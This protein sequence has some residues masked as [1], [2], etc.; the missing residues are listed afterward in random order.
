LPRKD[1]V[2]NQLKKKY[3]NHNSIL[4]LEDGE[5]FSGFGIGFEG[6]S[7]GEI[8]F[9]T[10]ITGYQEILTDPSYAGQIINFTFPHIGN[11]GA[12]YED[13]EAEKAWVK[14]AI[15]NTKVTTASNFRAIENLDAWLKK[16]KITAIC[17]VDTRKITLKIRKEGPQRASIFYHK[18]KKLDVKEILKLTRKLPKLE[19]IDLT[20]E[21]TCKKPYEWTGVK[22]WN[23]KGYTKQ[24]KFNLHIVA[25]DY[26]IKTNILRNF[27]ELGCK[28]TVVPSTISSEE[29]INIKPD[30]VFLSNGPGDPDKTG[31]YAV[32]TIR[33]ILDKKIPVFGICL[34]HQLLALSLG[35]KTKRMYQGHRGAN[36]PVKD[37]DE[38]KV[39][40]TCQ[41]H[42]FEVSKKTIP[43]DVEVTHL[44]LFDNSIEG[45]KSK[46][47]PAFSVQYHPE[48]S[49]GP[50]DSNYLFQKF[51]DLIQEHKRA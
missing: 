2:S 5:S 51:V 46:T 25:I 3:F 26:G 17:D 32:K 12:N 6:I 24:N 21:V 49:P 4:V 45:I 23:L 36:H 31:K 40:I 34:G 41:N 20:Q 18:T 15:L 14:G 42:G 28:V 16:N 9:N 44:S 7:S 48:A 33:N 47:K 38:N 8:C 11:V 43:K 30:G 10:S 50:H 27:S 37:L 39:E 29:I 22:L 19:K 13:L 35:A 1:L